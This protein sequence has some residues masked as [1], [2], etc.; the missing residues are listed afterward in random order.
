MSDK[1]RLHSLI[2]PMTRK[3]EKVLKELKEQIEGDD[4]K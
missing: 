1:K 4:E 2:K 3:Q